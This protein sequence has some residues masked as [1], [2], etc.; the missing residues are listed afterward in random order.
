MSGSDPY[1]RARNAALGL[2]STRPRS[3]AE[4]RVRLQS[5]F[6]A[7]L[8]EQVM[9]ALKEQ[10]L[11]DDPTFAR[12]WTQSRESFKP[13]SGWAVKRELIA[14]GVQAAL[15][16]E[17]VRDIDDEESAYRAGLGQAR[18]VGGADLPTFRRRLWGYLQRR[19][20]SQSVSRGTINRLWEDLDHERHPESNEEYQR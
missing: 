3:E 7:P 1:Q 6:P 14:K 9:A 11:V 12:L 13:R 15:A 8:V 19:G 4:V 10:K 5:R 17:A 20:F 2:L 18:K 16:D